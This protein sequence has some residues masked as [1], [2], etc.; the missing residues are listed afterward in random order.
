MAE[1]GRVSFSL[2]CYI[3]FYLHNADGF[4]RKTAPEFRGTDWSGSAADECVQSE[5]A[6]DGGFHGERSELCL[7]RPAN[8]S[9]HHFGWESGIHRWY[10]TDILQNTRGQKVAGEMERKWSQRLIVAV[11]FIK[12][13]PFDR[14]AVRRTTEATVVLPSLLVIVRMPSNARIQHCKI[15]GFG[16]LRKNTVEN[17][18]H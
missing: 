10:G 8:T 11:Y 18:R 3:F 6:L 14:L 9:L 12:T 5:G 2:T 15:D 7:W 13:A 1:E 17:N 16:T 4:W